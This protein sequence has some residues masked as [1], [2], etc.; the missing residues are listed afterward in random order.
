MSLYGATFAHKLIER[1]DYEE[2][3]A[4]AGKHIRREPDSP[5]P[6]HDRA[7]ALAF[8]GRY[9]E[10]LADYQKALDLDRE[11]GILH[12]GEIDDG[13]FSTVLAYSRTRASAEEQVATLSRY[14]ELLPKGTHLPEAEE[15]AQ[16]FRGLL[17][18]TWTKPRD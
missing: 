9:D 2:A 10:S 7:R 15:W 6:Y 5:E 14:Q 16:R 17:K 8:L 4:E 18:T 11:E 3:V 12:D 13:I 1:G